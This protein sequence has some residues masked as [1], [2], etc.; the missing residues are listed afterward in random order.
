MDNN[1][2]LEKYIDKVDRDQAALREDIRESERRTAERIADIEQKMDA[3]LNRIED[4]IAKSN[5]RLDSKISSVEGK[6][7]S[8]DTK[9]DAKFEAFRG[10]LREHRFF[11]ISMAL[12]IL[13]V[14]LATIYGI[15]TMVAMVK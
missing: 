2:I 14:C 3:R 11:K 15:A 12:G 8:L 4:M 1:Q 13:G 9:M 10:E 6:L 7:E 5:D